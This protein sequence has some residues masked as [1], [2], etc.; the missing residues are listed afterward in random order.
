MMVVIWYDKGESDKAQTM[1]GSARW[2]RGENT[3]YQ[4]WQPAFHPCD[5]SGR[6]EQTAA[7]CQTCAMACTQN[8][9]A[10]NKKFTMLLNKQLNIIDRIRSY[11]IYL[12]TGDAYCPTCSGGWGSGSLEPRNLKPPGLSNKLILKSH[13]HLRKADTQLPIDGR[14]LGRKQRPMLLHYGQDTGRR[15]TEGH[16]SENW[17]NEVRN[18][19]EASLGYI[20]KPHCRAVVAHTF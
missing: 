13:L 16:W 7:S 20:S 5:P 9:N 18:W 10:I 4:D 1:W 3:C 11:S 12:V 6:R 2:L 14:G 15:E 17:D 19:L 8:K